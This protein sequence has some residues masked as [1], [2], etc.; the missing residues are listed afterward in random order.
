MHQKI[1]VVVARSFGCQL[2]KLFGCFGL[3]QRK[4]NFHQGISLVCRY[5]ILKSRLCLASCLCFCPFLILPLDF[6][7]NSVEKRVSY[8]WNGM[9]T[10]RK[11]NIAD[12]VHYDLFI[13]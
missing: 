12:N 8:A 4:Y 9:L 11:F 1:L 13:F 2:D 7:K 3:W 10:R 5:V 6:K